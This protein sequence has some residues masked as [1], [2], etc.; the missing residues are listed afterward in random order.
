MTKLFFALYK[1]DLSFDSQLIQF[2]TLKLSDRVQNKMMCKI[3][4]SQESPCHVIH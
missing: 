2:N 1:V 3:G 4:K